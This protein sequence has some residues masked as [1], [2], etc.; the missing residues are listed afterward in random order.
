M[1]LRIYPTASPI[2][3]EDS[4]FPR[5]FFLSGALPNPFN[6]ATS[7][8]FGVPREKGG[9]VTI[10]IFDQ[11]GKKV[12]SLFNRQTEPGFYSVTWNGTDDENNTVAAGI[13]FA[14]FTS[15][16]F[17]ETKRAVLVK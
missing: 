11:T 9:L 16:G 12:K 1:T 4:R 8:K 10:E 5:E 6:M 3:Q 2:A 17:T 13:Y 7:F 15:G 14:R